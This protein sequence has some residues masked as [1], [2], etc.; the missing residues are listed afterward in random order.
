[1]LDDDELELPETRRKLALLR[2]LGGSSVYRRIFDPLGFI[3]VGQSALAV[4]LGAATLALQL[5]P[6][7]SFFLGLSLSF[8]ALE[9][10][11]SWY[12]VKP[13]EFVS[14]SLMSLAR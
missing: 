7:N 6:A 3:R 14:A 5:T 13:R 1:M 4:V 9:E 10:F 11:D 8:M 12:G 2:D